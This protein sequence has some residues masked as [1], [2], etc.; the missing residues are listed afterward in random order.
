LRSVRAVERLVFRDGEAIHDECRLQAQ[1]VTDEVARFLDQAEGRALGHTCL[2]SL[3]SIS[4][5]EARKVVGR[6]HVRQQY[7]VAPTGCSACHKLRVV[8]R[9]LPAAGVRPDA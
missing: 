6:L 2:S 5:D 9:A 7:A 3:F 1:D 8:I 4:F